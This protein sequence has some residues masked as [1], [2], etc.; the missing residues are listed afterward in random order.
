MAFWSKPKPI[1]K[2]VD[3][4]RQFKRTTFPRERALYEKLARDGQKPKIL[5]IACSDSR[6]SPSI[7][8]NVSPGSIFVARNIANIVPP[9]NPDGRPRSIGAAVEF[10]VKVLNVSDIVVKGHARCGGVQALMSEGEGLPPTDYLKPWVE[11]AAPARKLLPANF[12]RMP[13]E[14]QRR[15][16]EQAVIQNSILNLSGFPWVRERLDNGKL[17]VHGWHFDM[18]DG[19]LTV[20]D[21]SSGEWVAID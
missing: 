18:E 8:F 19:Q 9:H 20:L 14:E 21:H 13:P 1:D 6:V 17:K 2:L 10:A 3:G 16:A 15:A 7:I 4:Y 5:V 11:V 12:D